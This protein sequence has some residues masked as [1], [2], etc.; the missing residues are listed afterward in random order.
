MP[1]FS[2]P[3]SGLANNK[4]LM[5]DMANK[6]WQNVFAVAGLIAIL[7]TSYRLIVGLV[8]S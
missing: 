3:F 5:G 7:A 6:W 4:K 2:A 1:E 8:G